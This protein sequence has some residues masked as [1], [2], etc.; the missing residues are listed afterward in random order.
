MTSNGHCGGTVCS[1]G[2][3]LYLGCG[4]CYMALLL[5]KT[6]STAQQQQQNELYGVSTFLK[7]L[8][9]LKMGKKGM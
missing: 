3:I 2:T 7:Y 8:K 6:H 9:I 4:G 5:I 1:E